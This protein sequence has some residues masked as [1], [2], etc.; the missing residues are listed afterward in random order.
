MFLNGLIADTLKISKARGS[1]LS[2]LGS[3]RLIENGNLLCVPY[4]ENIKTC[5][6][7][8]SQRVKLNYVKSK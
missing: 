5:R 3:V 8:R 7:L 2:F 6:S 4:V 1:R